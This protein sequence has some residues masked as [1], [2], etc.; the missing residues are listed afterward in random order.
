MGGMKTFIF[1]DTNIP[2]KMYFLKKQVLN[3]VIQWVE[4]KQC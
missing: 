2:G 4:W 3:K 1:N